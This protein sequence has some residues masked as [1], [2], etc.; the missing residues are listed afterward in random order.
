VFRGLIGL[1]GVA[2]AACDSDILV[3]HVETIGIDTK[4]MCVGL[5]LVVLCV[6]VEL[7]LW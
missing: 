2:G 5:L 3:P 6:V 1:E 7:G 4:M